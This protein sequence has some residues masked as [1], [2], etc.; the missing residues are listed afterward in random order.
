METNGAAKTS[1]TNGAPKSA[2]AETN[3]AAKASK[4]AKPTPTEISAQPEETAPAEASAR[5]DGTQAEA[6][7]TVEKSAPAEKSTRADGSASA[8]ESAPVEKSAHADGSA[9]A[10]E[11]AS[12]D[13]S[14]KAEEAASTEKS[15]AVEDSAQVERAPAVG[16]A[17][18]DDGSAAVAEAVSGEE[19]ARAEGSA[20]DER[21]PSTEGSA[22]AEEAAAAE[23]SV[24]DEGASA[25][26]GSGQVEE[27]VSAGES[28]PVEKSAQADGSATAEGSTS[29]DGSV[30]A[31]EVA[32]AEEGARAAS[33]APAEK[34]SSTDGPTPDEG[35]ASVGSIKAEGVALGDGSA[36]LEGVAVLEVAHLC[37]EYKIRGRGGVLRAVDDVSFTIGRG[38][39]TAI[40]GE[41]GSG[42]TTTARMIL[43]L[44]AATSGTIRL[45]GQEAVGLRGARLRAARLAM[46]PVFQ[47]PYSSLDPMWTVERLIA[48]PLRAFG[49]G[50]R[51]TR[52]ARVAELLERVA[53]PASVTHRY[54]NELSGGQRQRVAIA[55]ALAIE[56]R[57]VVCDEAVSA[58]DVLVQKQI[59]TLL[60]DLQTRL[61][62]SY[63]FISHDL[64][65]VQALAHDVVVMREGK[66][67]E[68]GPVDKVLKSPSDPYTR[69]LL[70]AIPGAGVFGAEEIRETVN[71]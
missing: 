40:V 51:E 44:V 13:S 24:S 48:E 65:V 35:T 15:A 31:G 55:R 33:S 39:T 64:A 60:S 25:A 18:S 38:R 59:L 3:G 12:T 43:G 47:D 37:K 29:A 20:S 9:T 21:S 71:A 58:L 30:P 28:A 41:S 57:L 42:K 10:E 23:G 5:A 46:Q 2:A 16:G 27:V 54:P 26:D 63:L 45:D 14:V 52:R 19:G 1:A 8:E 50:D 4:T 56:P 67:V 53:L 70:D 62:V 61:G 11:S 36:Q 34:S 7:A 32:S 17:T 22:Q 49:I 69:R 68:Q 6:A 66:V